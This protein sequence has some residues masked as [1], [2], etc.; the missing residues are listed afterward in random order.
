[1]DKAK[2]ITEIPEW[3]SGSRLSYAE[4]LLRYKD[5]KMAIIE[6]GESSVITLDIHGHNVSMCLAY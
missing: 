6:C 2:N 4:N 3:F 1:M 5:N